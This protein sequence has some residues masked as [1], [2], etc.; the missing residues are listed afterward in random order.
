MGCLFSSKHPPISSDGVL[1]FGLTKEEV[2][3]ILELY[4]L[5]AAMCLLVSITLLFCFIKECGYFSPGAYAF[6]GP[7]GRGL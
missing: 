3:H 4:L 1:N 6:E 2:S 5:S 7:R